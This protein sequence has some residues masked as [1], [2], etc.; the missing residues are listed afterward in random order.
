MRLTYFGAGICG[1]VLF[2]GCAAGTDDSL[3]AGGSERPEA[4]IEATIEATVEAAIVILPVQ[5][6]LI[7]GSFA[8]TSPATLHCGS[9]ALS[10]T[11]TESNIGNA[12]AGSHFLHLQIFNPSNGQWPGASAFSLGRILAGVTRPLAG[13]FNFFNGPCDCLP[14]TYSITFRLFDDGGDLVAESNEGNNASNS[15]VVPAACP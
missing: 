6:D 10:F 5:P 15:V 12:G 7:V 13:T 11:A 4:T 3:G 8:V 2:V 9:Q 1:L 14:S